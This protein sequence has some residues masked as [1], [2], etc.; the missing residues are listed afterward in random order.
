[1]SSG[2]P[3]ISAAFS[4]LRIPDYRKLWWAGTFAF[5]SVQME[6]LLRGV[7]AWDLTERE[8]ALGLVYLCFGVALLIATPLGGVAADRLPKRKVLLASQ[9]ALLAGATGMGIVVVADV[10]Q[11]WMLLVASVIQGVAFGFFGPTR[12]SFTSEIVGRDQLGNAIT[13]SMLS[14]NGTRVL[15][16]SLA[17]ALAGLAVFGIGGAYL[18]A[19]GFSVVAFVLLLRCPSGSRPRMTST[20]NP[21]AEIIDG[22]RYV[23]ARPHLRRLVLSSFVIIMFGFNYVAFVPALV[24]GELELGDGSVG[25]IMSASSVGAVLVAVPIAGRADGAGVWRLMVASGVVFGVGVIA[26]GLSPVFLVAMAV[27]VVVGAGTTGYQSLSNTIALNMTD[28][29]HQ[30]RVQSLMML[31]FAGFGIA[32]AP[33]GL[34][35]ETIGL[36]QTIVAMGAVTLVTMLAYAARERH[37]Q[38]LI[39]RGTK[40]DPVTGDV[41]SIVG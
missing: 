34:L 15:A 9:G 39:E 26:L 21:L 14:M 41:G 5:M 35:A 31:S 18:V 25:L 36:R 38:V 19:A 40:D 22:V 4:S 10:V 12:V 24:K 7:L 33:L 13:L 6:F 17:G 32:A 30:G 3:G 37:V 16:P 20:A 1:M 28:D 29:T 2:R 27:V 8:G 11:F 23:A